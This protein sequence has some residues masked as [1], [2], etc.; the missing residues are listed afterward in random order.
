MIHSNPNV[1]SEVGSQ[2]SDTI[3]FYVREPCGADERESISSEKQVT[4]ERRDQ[5]RSLRQ[6]LA[7]SGETERRANPA[8][9]VRVSSAL[10]DHDRRDA[11]RRKPGGAAESG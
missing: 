7:F 5:A 4:G 11:G 9:P 6:R 10:R 2:S 3:K 1:P 8:G